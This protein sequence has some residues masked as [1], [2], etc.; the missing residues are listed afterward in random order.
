MDSEI[1]VLQCN[2]TCHLIPLVKGANII[3]C[4]WVYKI[5]RKSD[6]TVDRYKARLV[7]KG[8]KQRYGVEYEDNFSP[9][10]KPATIRLVLSM[11]ISQG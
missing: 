10:V 1:Q 8:F 2:D 5:K 6:G 4:R 9:V 3:D 7:A 11:A